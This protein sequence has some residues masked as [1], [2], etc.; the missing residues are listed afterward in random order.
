M[1]TPKL[2]RNAIT[3]GW[4]SPCDILLKNGYIED[5]GKDKELLEGVTIDLSGRVVIPGLVDGHTHLDKALSLDFC[6]N[7]EGT[8]V[9]AIQA[10]GKFKKS[11]S[12]DEIYGRAER[13]L[14]MFISHGTT[15]VRTH[16][17]VDNSSELRGIEALIKL[18]EAY[19]E[20][21]NLQ[22]I[23]FASGMVGPMDKGITRER[24]ET[25]IRMGADVAGGSP[26]LSDNPKEHIDVVFKL[27]MERDLSIDMHIDESDNPEDQTLELLAEK[28]MAEGYQGRVV[29]GH[30]CSL[31][32]MDDRTAGRIIEKV[33]KANISIITM[34][35]CNLYLQG[36]KDS[37]P[38]RRGI[39]RVKELEEA[40]VNVY[41]ASDNVQDPFGP[42]GRADPL[43]AVMLTALAAQWNPNATSKL[44][45]MV[46][47]RPAKA[48]GL[49]KPYGVQV[50]AQ[51]D[52]LVLN[53]TQPDKVVIDRPPRLLVF[54]SGQIVSTGLGSAELGI[55]EPEIK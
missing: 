53:S 19:R 31:A 28:T 38:I 26:T 15:T 42:Y 44:L 10:M 51:A 9:G 27:A 4:E 25:S 50:G 7:P 37:Q 17:D 41:C 46:T 8:L 21:V 24:Y 32:A 12:V 49:S 1:T 43:E 3:P 45:E 2:L 29:A 35:F 14:Q 30:C 55:L 39:T 16:V 54:H 22:V 6:E 18:R 47:T 23:A 34:P 13:C 48:I 36:R 40:G 11:T 33:S 52:L 20:K 5:I